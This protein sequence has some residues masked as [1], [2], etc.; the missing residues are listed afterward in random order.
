LNCSNACI[1]FDTSLPDDIEE[2]KA[3]PQRSESL[4]IYLQKMTT[5]LMLSDTPKAFGLFN[6]GFIVVTQKRNKHRQMLL[7]HF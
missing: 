5:K 2:P 1:S 3:F 7:L 6:A 4:T